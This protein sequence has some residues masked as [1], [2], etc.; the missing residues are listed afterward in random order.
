MAAI[1]DS[2]HDDNE[3]QAIKRSFLN[4]IK[5]KV[6]AVEDIVDDYNRQQTILPWDRFQQWIYCIAIVTFDIELGQSIEV[7]IT[8]YHYCLY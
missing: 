4:N 7:F 5:R 8:S 1:T 6:S 3:D 2:S